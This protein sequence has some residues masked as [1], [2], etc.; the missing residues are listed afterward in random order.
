MGFTEAQYKAA[1][2][3][4][5][6]SGSGTLT[7][8]QLKAILKR[9]VGGQRFTDEMVDALIK[10]LETNGVTKQPI[11]TDA[12]ASCFAKVLGDTGPRCTAVEGG[13][14]A[15]FKASR[16]YAPLNLD[17]SAGPLP[18]VITVHGACDEIAGT[19]TGADWTYMEFL[20]EE[21]A[22]KLGVVVLMVGMPDDD[23]DYVNGFV[24][25]S[26]THP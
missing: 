16:F 15:R 6:Q 4:F 26:F 20:S 10:K 14:K 2:K 25:T 5:D 13:G 3:V 18:A 8:E 17:K 19:L 9:P 23:E 7:P 11:V 1:F 21:L 12:V 22:S 24:S